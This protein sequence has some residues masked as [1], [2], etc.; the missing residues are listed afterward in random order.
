MSKPYLKV[1]D[2]RSPDSAILLGKNDSDK[3]SL[4]TFFAKNCSFKFFDVKTTDD[5]ILLVSSKSIT[6]KSFTELLLNKLLTCC[7]FPSIV[8]MLLCFGFPV[9]ITSSNHAVIFSWKARTTF[10]LPFLLRWGCAELNQGQILT[11]IADS[12]WRTSSL[13]RLDIFIFRGKSFR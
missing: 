5:L 13:L 7:N 8:V 2:F 12:I 4:C 10:E 11:K 1:I 3:K 6:L 9:P